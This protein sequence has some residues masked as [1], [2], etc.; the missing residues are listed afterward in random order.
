MVS[1]SN[2]RMEWDKKIIFRY[3]DGVTY[4]VEKYKKKS[5]KF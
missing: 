4:W 3:K 1:G 2:S 5:Y